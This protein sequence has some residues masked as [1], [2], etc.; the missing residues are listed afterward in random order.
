MFDSRWGDWFGL[1]KSFDL[2][3]VSLLTWMDV[4]AHNKIWL[5]LCV[6]FSK[7]VC[8][9][10]NKKLLLLMVLSTPC[11]FMSFNMS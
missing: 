1:A 10:Y 7:L 11:F 9:L 8:L 5:K 6:S 3:A 4:I 2:E